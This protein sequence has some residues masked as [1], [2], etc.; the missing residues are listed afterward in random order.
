MLRDLPAGRLSPHRGLEV[1]VPG[2][3]EHPYAASQHQRLFVRMSARWFAVSDAERHSRREDLGRAQVLLELVEP[4][5]PIHG[6]RV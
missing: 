3:R 4:L 5:V 6:R 2:L 1:V